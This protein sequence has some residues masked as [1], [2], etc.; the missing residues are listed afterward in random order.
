LRDHLRPDQSCT[1][2]WRPLFLEREDL[3]LAIGGWIL[4]RALYDLVGDWCLAGC[5][6]ENT[7]PK[8]G[9]SF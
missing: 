6:A 3:L 5:A 1:E 8:E 9:G 2:P 4:A 7:E